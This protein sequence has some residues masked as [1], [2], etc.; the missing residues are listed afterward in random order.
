MRL[1]ENKE[2]I[3]SINELNDNVEKQI[4]QFRKMRQEFE[5]LA[6]KIDNEHSKKFAEAIAALANG[7]EHLN[8]VTLEL[9][10]TLIEELMKR[11]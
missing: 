9:S 11:A 2:I 8:F 3:R 1:E 5:S 7:L 6:N 10:D 4:R